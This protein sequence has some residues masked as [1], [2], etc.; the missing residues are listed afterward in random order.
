MAVG[1]ETGHGTHRKRPYPIATAGSPEHLSYDYQT[2][3]FL[4]RYRTRDR[5]GS[6]RPGRFDI[7][8]LYLPRRVYSGKLRHRLSPGGHLKVDWEMQRA[9]AWFD[10]GDTIRT[11]EF[12]TVD[13][14]RGRSSEL[15]L[16]LIGILGLSTSILYMLYAR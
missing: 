3:R 5:K 6:A 7:T 4:L 14:G 13:G 12:W 16:L 1:D 11:V 9:W 10:S 15:S 8:E 2:K